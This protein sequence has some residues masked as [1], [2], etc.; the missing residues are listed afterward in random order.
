MLKWWLLELILS[1][2]MLT[3]IQACP[4]SFAHNSS[5]PASPQNHKDLLTTAFPFISATYTWMLPFFNSLPCNLQQSNQQQRMMMWTIRNRSTVLACVFRFKSWQ[6]FRWWLTC[7]GESSTQVKE[8]TIELDWPIPYKYAM[9]PSFL[10]RD[11][12]YEWHL[13]MELAN[14]INEALDS[15]LCRRCTGKSFC[16]ATCKT[17][18]YAASQ[19]HAL[20]SLAKSRR[21]FNHLIQS[22]VQECHVILHMMFA[23][24]LNWQVTLAVSTK[25]L[26][27]GV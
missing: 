7:A 3:S 25:V 16:A 23:P 17:G 21:Q 12:K 19:S 1:M 27:R 22:T 4:L 15:K 26:H 8:L 2:C 11:N 10:G 18:H 6:L 5:S 14:S 24:A 20:D 13:Y 9:Y